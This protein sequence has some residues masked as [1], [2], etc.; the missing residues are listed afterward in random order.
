MQMVYGVKRGGLDATVLH[1]VELL[2]RSYAN[3]K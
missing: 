2:E 3:G 1:V